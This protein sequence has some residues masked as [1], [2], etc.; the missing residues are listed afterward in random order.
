MYANA[1][2]AANSSDDVSVVIVSPP[3]L[4]ITGVMIGVII[5]SVTVDDPQPPP[6]P[7]P[8]PHPPPQLDVVVFGTNNVNDEKLFV[9][10]VHTPDLT[11]QSDI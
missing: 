11:V 2:A 3:L 7:H 8:P 4:M 1:Y 6:H 9:V 5:G 10:N